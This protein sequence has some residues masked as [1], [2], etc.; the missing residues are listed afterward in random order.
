MGVTPDEKQF[1][2][3]LMTGIITSALLL[4]EMHDTYDIECVG[5]PDAG[6]TNVIEMTHKRHGI[7][8]YRITV[9]CVS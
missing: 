7:P 1:A 3:I 9:E 4:A 6:A 8:K 2:E 5:Y